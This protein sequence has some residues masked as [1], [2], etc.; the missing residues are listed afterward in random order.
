MAAG[1]QL[2]SVTPWLQEP[3]TQPG[4]GGLFEGARSFGLEE[5]GSPAASLFD[6]GID[7]PQDRAEEHRLF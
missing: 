4:Q 5:A 6:S 2:P 7:L 3:S 1:E